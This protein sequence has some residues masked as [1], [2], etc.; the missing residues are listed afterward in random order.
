MS[1][2][3]P[4]AAPAGAVV[5]VPSEFIEICRL[6]ASTLD[7]GFIACGHC[8]E[9]ET[10]GD[11]D[12][13]PEFIRQV[14]AL[15]APPAQ[16]RGAGEVHPLLLRAQVTALAEQLRDIR[17]ECVALRAVVRAGDDLR[18]SLPPHWHGEKEDAYDE[19][20]DM[21]DGDLRPKNRHTTPTLSAA[22][23]SNAAAVRDHATIYATIRAYRLTN[24]CFE[25]T[26]DPYPL[27]DAMT[28]SGNTI[29][30]GEEQMRLLT[31]D[32][33]HALNTSAHTEP[34]DQGV[35][36]GRSDAP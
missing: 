32:I 21:L 28:C 35:G 2:A 19:E 18:A 13:V 24:M 25:N 26:S 36:E 8:G 17:D 11:I 3:T 12:F 29:A 34:L 23:P 4:S 6:L 7:G 20:R 33:W 15:T 10:T 1:P 22:T 5:Q 27:V 9:Q 16:Q 31:D 14:A 30:D